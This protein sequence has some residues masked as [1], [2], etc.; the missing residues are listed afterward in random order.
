MVSDLAG[1]ERRPEARARD[2]DR[3]GHSATPWQAS[4]EPNRRGGEGSERAAAAA[5]AGR[6]DRAGKRAEYSLD[7]PGQSDPRHRYRHV[8]RERRCDDHI[9]RRLLE[10]RVVE[11]VLQRPCESEELR[12]LDKR[13]PS[14]GIK[15]GEPIA[16]VE[17]EVGESEDVPRYRARF[18]QFCI[19]AC[20]SRNALIV[21]Q[22]DTLRH[23]IVVWGCDVRMSCWEVGGGRGHTLLRR[24]AGRTSASDTAAPA[25]DEVAAQETCCNA[26]QPDYNTGAA[27]RSARCETRALPSDSTRSA[28]QRSQGTTQPVAP[29]G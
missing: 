14:F 5:A 26:V 13:A 2:N 22:H 6:I 4:C 27:P 24:Q 7:G 29:C 9:E 23:A 19:I 21:L 10:L 15:H 16:T 20:D 3:R 8:E 18:A 28:H 12:N 17:E 1:G 11:L 25:E